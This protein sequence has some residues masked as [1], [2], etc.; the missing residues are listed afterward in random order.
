MVVETANAN[1]QDS[2]EAEA[3]PATPTDWIIRIPSGI[4]NLPCQIVQY[5]LR[6]YW[7]RGIRSLPY[8]PQE[9]SDVGIQVIIQP[10]VEGTPDGANTLFS[11][12][13]AA[14]CA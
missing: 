3:S 10:A 7:K 6:K 14:G 9:Q 1:M 11:R 8:R 2:R 13:E 4:Y 5:R 12:T